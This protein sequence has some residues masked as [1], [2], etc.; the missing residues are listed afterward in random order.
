MSISSSAVAVIASMIFFASSANAS[1]KSL[2][3]C[4]N[5]DKASAIKQKIAISFNSFTGSNTEVLES[6]YSDDVQY[7]DPISS[8]IGLPSVVKL[9]TQTYKNVQM[10]KYN[11]FDFICENNRISASYNLKIQIAGLN[12]GQPYIVKGSSVFEIN[13]MGLVKS[14]RDYFDLGSMVYEKHPLTGIVIKK[15]KAGLAK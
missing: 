15:I 9:L 6:F 8:V 13:G 11:F 1:E 12:G 4:K 5:P 14:H 2:D 10:I 3:L 7:S